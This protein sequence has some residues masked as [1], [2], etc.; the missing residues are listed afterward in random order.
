[1]S[2]RRINF[3]N[4]WKEVLERF[5]EYFMAFFFPD[6]HQEIDWNKGYQ[7]LDQELSQ[8]LEDAKLTHRPGG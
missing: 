5:Y 2:R 7:F 6:V 4:S 8:F 1:M 3:D